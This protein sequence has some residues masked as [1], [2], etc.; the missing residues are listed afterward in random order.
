MTRVFP[1]ADI[2]SDHDLLIMAMKVKLIRRQ[3]KDHTRL[4][5]DIERLKDTA[6][7]DEFRATLGRKFTPLLLL[8]NI[9][10]VS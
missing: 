5:Y 6:I 3:R 9:Q 1:G 8:D 7:L 4:R 10:D 2:G